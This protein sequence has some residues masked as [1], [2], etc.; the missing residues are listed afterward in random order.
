VIDVYAAAHP[1]SALARA[2]S[3]AA[4]FTTVTKDGQLSPWTTWSSVHR[5]I[6][7]DQHGILDFGQ[8]LDEVDRKYAPLWALA[9]AAGRTVG[10][11]GSLHTHPLPPY[12]DGCAFWIPDVFAPSHE[13]KPAEAEGFQEINLKMS[14][15]SGRNVSRRIPV[16]LAAKFLLSAPRLGITA[17]TAA[18]VARQL[19]AELVTPRIKLRRRTFQS[20][21]AFDIFQRQLER[22]KPDF[23]TFFTNHVASAMHRYWAAT[24]PEDY[25]ESKYDDAWR[26]AYRDEIDW[27][28][29]AFDRM[30]ERLVGF[31]D[32]NPG[33]SLWIASS[34]GQAAVDSQQIKRQVLLSEVDRFMAALGFRPGEWERRPAMEPRVI[35]KVPEARA[36]EFERLAQSIRVVGRHSIA[37]VNLSQGVFRLHPGVIQDAQEEYCELDG[38]RIPFAE[39]GFANVLIEDEAGQSAYHVPEGSLIVYSPGRSNATAARAKVSTLEIAPAILRSLD[40][41][42]P[43]YMVDTRIAA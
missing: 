2:M 35:I 27:A 30:L 39:I 41:Q 15:A 7:D 36:A 23:C 37:C 20:I 6:A 32:R 26:A 38:R 24:F 40:I 31:V 29:S 8:E 17:R 3:S 4:S 33:Y 22:T 28:M 1:G 34:M 25:P 11:V 19:A 5:G 10:N 14:R 42:P 13:C 21:L 18:S 9:A 43:S 16:D 12:V